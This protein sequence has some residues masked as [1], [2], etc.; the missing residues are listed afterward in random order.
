MTEIPKCPT[1]SG[2]YYIWRQ[3]KVF[4]TYISVSFLSAKESLPKKMIIDIVDSEVADNR[5]RWKN[6]TRTSLISLR[7]KLW[8]LRHALAGREV[9]WFPEQKITK[10]RWRVELF[11]KL[12]IGRT[13]IQTW[14]KDIFMEAYLS[15]HNR[16]WQKKIQYP[17]ADG[18]EIWRQEFLRQRPKY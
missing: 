15:L 14:D 2:R 11:P 13:V 12:S 16:R 1:T 3:E 17:F 10:R 5:F 18:S 9:D 7:T 6:K 4:T 8:I